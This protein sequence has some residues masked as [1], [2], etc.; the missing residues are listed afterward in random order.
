[1]EHREK[2]QDTCQ[3][4]AFSAALWLCRCFCAYLFTALA[5]HSQTWGRKA[6]KL[7]ELEYVYVC[8]GGCMVERTDVSLCHIP[9]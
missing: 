7:L 2:H 8:G 4:S 9:S 1:M 3:G 6:S 5:A